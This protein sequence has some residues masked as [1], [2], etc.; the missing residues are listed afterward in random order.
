MVMTKP[1]A[2]DSWL[3]T[4]KRVCALQ[5][6][7]RCQ[8]QLYCTKAFARYE[9]LVATEK[10][11]KKLEPTCYWCAECVL[12]GRPRGC[13]VRTAKGPGRQARLASSVGCGN[14]E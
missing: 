13:H 3:I 4:T 9:C 8:V 2:K 7:G 1:L 12:D 5:E 11:M 14:S 10:W 6:Q